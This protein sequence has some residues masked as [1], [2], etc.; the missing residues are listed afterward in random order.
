MP[1]PPL[2]YFMTRETE[3]NEST[4]RTIPAT[5]SQTISVGHFHMAGEYMAVA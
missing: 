4:A 3:T 1:T 5:S 2:R